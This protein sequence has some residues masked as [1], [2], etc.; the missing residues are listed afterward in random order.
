M[1]LN[2]KSDNGGCAKTT[3]R[4]RNFYFCFYQSRPCK[5]HSGIHPF[6]ETICGR[7][8][9]ITLS[10]YNDT[11]AQPQNH[12]MGAA[13]R[14]PAGGESPMMQVTNCSLCHR[15]C[16]GEVVSNTT[17]I[18]ILEAMGIARYKRCLFISF[19]AIWRSLFL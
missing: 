6:Q 11:S 19:Y 2:R 4:N 13:D 8:F 9:A 15:P 12:A 1:S 3:C 18:L 14:D 5:V 10:A 7:L 17:Q 16:V